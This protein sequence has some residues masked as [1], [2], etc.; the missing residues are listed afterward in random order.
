M[1]GVTIGPSPDLVQMRLRAAGM[2]PVSNVVDASNY[3]ML[4]LGKPIHTFDAA[5]VH[6]GKIIVRRATAGERL[7][8]L[9]HVERVLDTETLLIS[10]PR[11]PLG[12]AGVMGGANS[13][14]S[15]TTT[16]V[17]V[18]SAIFDPVN[19]RRTGQ[20]YALRSE[21]S[22]RFEK[23]QEHR[24]A[25]IGADRTARLLAEWAR[26]TVAPGAVDT[27]PSEPAPSR[28]A[29]R[30]SRVTKLL[31][32]PFETAEQRE[33][34]ARVGVETEPAPAGV[35][36]PIAAETEAAPALNV[37]AAPGVETLTAIVPSWRRDLEIEADVIEEIARVAGYDRL[38]PSIPDTALPRFRP[39]PLSL[40]EAVREALAGAGMTEVVTT[41]LVSPEHGTR[42]PWPVD[43]GTAAAG[44]G[45]PE[46]GAETITVRNPLSSQHSVLRRGVVASLLD[47]L[48]VNERQG[49]DDVAIFEVGKGYERRGEQP[50]EWW[51]LAFL[52]AGS[53][54]DAGWSEPGREA[55]LY[56]ALGIA[57]LVAARLRL[58]APAVTVDG[59]GFPFHPGRAATLTACRQTGAVGAPG[60]QL[61]GSVVEL[62][63]VVLAAWELRH[64]HVLVGEL[65]IAGLEGGRIPDI[66]AEEPSRRQD[67]ERDVAV[68]VPESLESGFVRDV[69]AAAAG[70]IAVSVR[71][72]D[73]YRGMPLAGDEKSLAF[74]IVFRVP[75]RTLVDDEID[76]AMAAVHAAI[77]NLEGARLRV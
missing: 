33:L 1:S 52:I 5:A 6:D 31:G 24:L 34:L 56:D 18:E 58:A 68:V 55:D 46:A 30:P 71:L 37:L 25:R 45:G 53:A 11:G 21:A 70:S 40:R 10:D 44:T 61:S 20:R 72:F 49:R 67:A 73:L 35:E 57:E 42:L 77:G 36:I 19:I 60:V 51:R 8:T 15:G 48:A 76:G 69:I 2:R 39:S 65:A 28:V 13:E 22:L 27:D 29:F 14:I 64:E 63:P 75:D 43:D 54:V 47:V 12:I 26:G 7:E 4:E 32:V 17:I 38:A 41:A 9:D 66:R 23:G 74:R 50:H 3:V 16:D 59:R 62:H